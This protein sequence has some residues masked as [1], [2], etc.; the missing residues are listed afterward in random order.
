[1]AWT[2]EAYAAF[3]VVVLIAVVGIGIVLTERKGVHWYD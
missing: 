3:G 1:M 2:I